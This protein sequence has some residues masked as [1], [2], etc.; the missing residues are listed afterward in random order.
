MI[1]VEECCAKI[2][3]M[4]HGKGNQEGG[5]VILIPMLDLIEKVHLNKDLKVKSR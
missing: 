2:N 3:C 5:I 1:G 4:E